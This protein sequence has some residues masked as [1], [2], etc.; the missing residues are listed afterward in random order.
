MKYEDG[1]I[2]GPEIVQS[3][4]NFAQRTASMITPAE[5]GESHTS[6]LPLT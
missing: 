5:F 4:A 1:P 2:N 6:N 3:R